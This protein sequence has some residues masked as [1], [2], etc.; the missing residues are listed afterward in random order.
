MRMNTVER[1][2]CCTSWFQLLSLWK[3]QKMCPFIWM[4]LNITFLGWR[5]FFDVLQIELVRFFLCF[6]KWG[7]WALLGV[8]VPGLSHL[9]ENTKLTANHVLSFCSFSIV[10]ATGGCITITWNRQ[11]NLAMFKILPHPR[12]RRSDNN[13]YN[14]HGTNTYRSAPFL[15]KVQM[16]RTQISVDS[17]RQ[18]VADLHKVRF[19]QTLLRRC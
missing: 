16:Y 12:K 13:L 10:M 2:L 5:L 11:S 8:N 4:V 17:G 19:K 1:L 18:H 6:S 9:N 14:A 7:K 15:K 3:N